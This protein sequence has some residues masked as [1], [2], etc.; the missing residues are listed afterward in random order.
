M[1]AMPP[2]PFK[3]DQ[4]ERLCKVLA[5]TADGLTGSEI[6]MLLNQTRIAD[7][8]PGITKWRRLFNALAT[9]QNGDQHGG[10]VLSF[11]NAALAPARYAGNSAVLIKRRADVNVVLALYGLEFM[12]DSK[13]H[14]VDR[15]RSLS[16]AEQRASRLR[17]GLSSRG[18]HPDVLA[19][20]RAELVENNAFHAVLEA[21]KSV[22]TKLRTRA[23][24]TSD[25]AALVDAALGGDSPLLRI[26]GYATE[27]ERSEQRGFVNLVKG[28]FGAFRNPT[29]H[30]PRAEWNL[31][32]EDALDLFSLASYVHR[33]LDGATI[34]R[35]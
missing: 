35:V 13:F 34:T 27:S 3:H 28:L 14:R 33:R 8:D 23:S 16:D 29:A 4:L 9:R 25:G 26:N 12:A 20:C 21:C 30:E 1:K 18:V 22:A 24:L 17:A 10:G 7:P 32:E 6:G 5:D 15:A 11:I 19:A 2:S 31:T